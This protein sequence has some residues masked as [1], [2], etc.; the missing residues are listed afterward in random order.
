MFKKYAP[1]H[2]PQPQHREIQGDTG[3]LERGII[4][5]SPAT[6]SALN[7]LSKGQR[8]TGSDIIASLIHSADKAQGGGQ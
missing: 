1:L 5:L 3:P 2:P 6:W 4:M 8:R 7:G